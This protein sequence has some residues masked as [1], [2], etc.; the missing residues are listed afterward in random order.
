MKNNSFYVYRKSKL[1]SD[2][3]EKENL[4]PGHIQGGCRL[5][6]KRAEGVYITDM[7][8]KQ[9]IDCLAGA[10]TLALGHNHAVVREAIEGFYAIVC[11]FTYT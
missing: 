3:R 9:Y 10:G 2:A 6:L 4:M 8:G 7:D 5:R 11:T 1:I